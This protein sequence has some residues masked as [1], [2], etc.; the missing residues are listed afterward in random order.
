MRMFEKIKY[1]YAKGFYR[2][3]HLERLLDSQVISMAEYEEILKGENY[4]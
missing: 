1:Y 3:F 2:K 4:G